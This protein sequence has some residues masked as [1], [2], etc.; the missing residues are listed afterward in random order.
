MTNII[1]TKYQN[2]HSE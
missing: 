1:C 2:I